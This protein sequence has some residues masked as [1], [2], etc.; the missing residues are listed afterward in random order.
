MAPTRPDPEVIDL[1]ELDA[2]RSS[3]IANLLHAF[4]DLLLKCRLYPAEHPSVQQALSR[5]NNQSQQLQNKG[6]PLV[7]VSRDKRL[8][9]NGH[10]VGHA[11]AA[12]EDARHCDG[13]LRL[14]GITAVAFLAGCSG[15]EMLRCASFLHGLPEGVRRAPDLRG[16]L[17]DMKIEH[18]HLNP[19]FGRRQP[20][21]APPEEVPETDSLVADRLDLFHGPPGID[22]PPSPNLSGVD[23]ASI[24]LRTTDLASF[25][26]SEHD[27]TRLD[28]RGVDW[29]QIPAGRLD[30]AR[31]Q[32][33]QLDQLS[34]SFA[35]VVEDGDIA[36]W[37][38]TRLAESR[39]FLDHVAGDSYRRFDAFLRAYLEAS[40]AIAATGCH[41]EELG[42]RLV[43]LAEAIAV[44]GSE[45][46]RAILA[47][48][49]A[50][51]IVELDP[52]P[53]VRFLIHSSADAATVRS[54]V[55]KAMVHADALAGRVTVGLAD[56]VR[57]AEAD[58]AFLAIA[59]ALEWL[60]PGRIA[61][62]DLEP[63]LSA[64][65]AVNERRRTLEAPIQIRTRATQLLRWLCRPDLVDRLLLG[66]IDGEAVVAER[67][68]ATLL[69]LGPSAGDL[70]LAE[71]KRSMNPEI[72]MVIVDLV[73]ELL[74]GE[75]EG[76]DTFTRSFRALLLEIDHARDQPWYYLRNLL[77]VIRKIGDDRF[78]EWIERF[79]VSEDSRVRQ[80]AVV[81]CAEMDCP[82]ARVL[83]RG[84][85]N[86]A[87]V[88]S[89]DALEAVC[90]SL[91]DDEDFDMRAFL[92]HLID[93]STVGG[94]RLAAILR[95]AS[96]PADEVVESLGLVL[97]R[98]RGLIG[99]KPFYPED[100]REMAAR[101]L[102]RRDT[103]SAAHAL[104]D[105]TLDPAERVRAAGSQA[106]DEPESPPWEP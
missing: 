51:V 12:F 27:I 45:Q 68:R 57:S 77:L 61:D 105:L 17:L 14:R 40:A 47:Q 60:V 29:R 6:K 94:V 22:A 103:P 58:E 90:S 83:L 76:G 106:T 1:A 16:A 97:N 85:A 78:L 46:E 73:A 89:A 33:W 65:T 28:F 7:F 95:L 23:P 67:A 25:D 41:D 50:A 35:D 64:L 8:S 3:D 24:D 11:E 48:R 75:R 101:E 74:S 70:L 102:A 84:V 32:G 49:I 26:F 5:W 79:L 72:R 86:R 104:R 4:R 18:V 52:D 15:P 92:T 91:A 88:G 44:V 98:K 56:R 62:G 82:D 54:E 19:D 66:T 100:L 43:R 87:D 63:A 34:Y 13:F 80:E 38:P 2:P 53:I 39:L 55:L 31:L 20:R 36:R 59:E 9:V 37:D 81:A 10:T 93:D 21:V 69:Q 99:R 42:T 96:D 71:L 30:P